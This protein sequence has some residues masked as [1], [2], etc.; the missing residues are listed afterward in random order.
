MIEVDI[1]ETAINTLALM[2]S[3]P[4]VSFLEEASMKIYLRCQHQR[5]S[6]WYMAGYKVEIRMEWWQV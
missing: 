5:S 6:S 4:P 2:A 3:W 1:T